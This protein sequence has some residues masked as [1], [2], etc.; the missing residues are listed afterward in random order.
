MT[1]RTSLYAFRLLAFFCCFCVGCQQIP[2]TSG[3]LE[4][5]IASPHVTSHQ[6]RVLVN[7]YVV[8]SSH[9]VESRADKI[10]SDD[11]DTAVR[12]SALLWKINGIAAAFQAAARQ[13]PFGAYLD[14]WVLNRQMT[15][16]F[17]SPQGI[18]LFGKWQP[19][20][21]AEC[22]HLEERLR[23][24]NETVS[25][26]IQHV[27]D[28]VEKFTSDYPLKSLYLDREPMASR[29]IE[30][31]QTPSKEIIQV[32]A[33]LDN[34]I[35]AL[36]KLT[37][38]YAEHLPKQAR[39]QSELFLIDATQMAE[40]QRPLQDLTLVAEAMSRIADTSQTVP[41][42][43]QDE[44]KKLSALVTQERV[45]AMREVDSMRDETL[46]QLQRERAIILAAVG[47]EREASF[48]SLRDERIAVTRDFKDEVSRA[49]EAAD[50]ITRKRTVEVMRQAPS[51][52][53]HFFWRAWQIGVIFVV[54]VS[55]AAGIICWQIARL[56]LQRSKSTEAPVILESLE[57]SPSVS[58]GWIKPRN[59]A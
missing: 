40:V 3:L 34:N 5:Q 16:L 1:S 13:D 56:R 32:I 23:K 27:E 7:E 36:R 20:A 19:E 49:F 31:I 38:I 41:L 18:E 24:I 9:R 43:I 45:Q 12:K 51:M 2:Q 54:L 8:F 11:P 35:D 37:I 58:R 55:I 28:F 47:Q 59:A 25:G 33:H 10:L 6:L 30:Q 15:H 39:W 52:I 4:R 48:A 14:L 22:Y 29:Y 53:D 57:A 17:E 21:V 50:S 44:L 42:L 26:E 46:A